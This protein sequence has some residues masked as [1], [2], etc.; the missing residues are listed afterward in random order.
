[1]KAPLPL[2]T[3]LVVV[4]LVVGLSIGLGVGFIAAPTKTV[5]RVE[6]HTYSTT[7]TVTATVI[8]MET[9]TETKTRI[10]TKTLR[11]TLYKV[12]TTTATIMAGYKPPIPKA[13]TPLKIL[14]LRCWQKDNNAYI[15][16]ELQNIGSR[17]LE[18]VKLGII[19]LDSEDKIVYVG[20]AF[21]QIEI[22]LPVQKT[23]VFEFQ[24]NLLYERCHVFIEGWSETEKQPYREFEVR[25]V[26]SFI[27]RY[28]FLHVVG[29]VVNIGAR[30]AEEVEV[31][32]TF[33]N[34]DGN[35]VSS[36][37]KSVVPSE[38]K[39]KSYGYFDVSTSIGVDEIDHW[40][41]Q[42]QSLS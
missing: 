24:P 28:G 31:V 38:L 26:N 21:S 11:E 10:E 12:S 32:V 41:I 4:M 36:Y 14:S 9:L 19:L 20:D 5:E 42:V 16:A 2:S 37:R 25:D 3:I 1:M 7:N 35:I 30:T 40:L 13:D 6:V 39:P 17:N 8:K 23:P 34:R 33:Y 29:K 18:F 27:D 15:Y 22:L